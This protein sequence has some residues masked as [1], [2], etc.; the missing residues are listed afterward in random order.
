MSSCLIS[1]GDKGP[2]KQ[3]LPIPLTPQQYLSWNEQ[4]KL[5]KS[6]MCE[7]GMEDFQT[8]MVGIATEPPLRCDGASKGP[9]GGLLF[10]SCITGVCCIDP[11]PLPSWR[12]AKGLFHPD[13]HL[14]GWTFRWTTLFFHV[15]LRSVS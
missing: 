2:V 1:C 7:S 15:T 6:A 12:Q 8:G 9:L 14:C 3:L 4:Q 10:P 11:C 5:L 13:G